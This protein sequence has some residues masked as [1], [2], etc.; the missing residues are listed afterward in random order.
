MEIAEA[1]GSYCLTITRRVNGQ[2]LTFVGEVHDA[3]GD[4]SM[5]MADMVLGV[6]REVRQERSALTS[7]S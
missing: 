5:L 2:Y 1:C 6:S 7:S 4:P 3:G